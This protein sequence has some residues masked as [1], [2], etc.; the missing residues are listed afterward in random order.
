MFF[1]PSIKKE[2]NFYQKLQKTDQS[3]FSRAKKLLKAMAAQ[4]STTDPDHAKKPDEGE[5]MAQHMFS[6]S[7]GLLYLQKF[8]LD[9][10]RESEELEKV[11]YEKERRR[12]WE[13]Y[14]K[15]GG[16]K[17][18]KPSDKDEA[19]PESATKNAD[20]DI[21]DLKASTEDKV[22][23]EDKNDQFRF[24][25]QD[26]FELDKSN[27]LFK[28]ISRHPDVFPMSNFTYLRKKLKFK[29]GDNKSGLETSTAA[30]DPADTT[31]TFKKVREFNQRTMDVYEKLIMDEDIAHPM[32]AQ[33]PRDRSVS[34]ERQARRQRVGLPPLPEFKP[35]VRTQPSLDRVCADL[36]SNF[37]GKFRP[38]KFKK[39]K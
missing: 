35:L 22:K 26:E 14:K 5:V 25:D 6:H 34:P 28:I 13:E 29:I 9:V 15:K 39:K 38:I 18:Q 30:E 2:A 31:L 7:E 23:T 37:I 21:Y 27:K 12:R 3:G 16:P 4:F 19:P 32:S 11:K 36:A 33:E 20:N 24:T 1:S 10:Q 17:T 8:R